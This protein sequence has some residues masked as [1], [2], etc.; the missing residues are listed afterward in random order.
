MADVA[1]L[2]N[3]IEAA[4]LLNTSFLFRPIL[5][6]EYT[7]QE[8]DRRTAGCPAILYFQ[9]SAGENTAQIRRLTR[10]PA[11]N[12]LSLGDGRNE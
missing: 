12:R 9:K 2:S 5:M 8:F 4:R 10:I 7:P 1:E 3:T 11:L 6:P